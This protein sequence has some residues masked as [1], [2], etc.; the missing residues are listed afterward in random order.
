VN[1][2]IQGNGRTRFSD[3]SIGELVRSIAGDTATLVRKE[4]QLARQEMTETVTGKARGA[5]AFAAAG[6]L[7]LIALVFLGAAGAAALDLVL[8]RWASRLIVAGVFLVAM[9]VLIAAGAR[10]MSRTK[11]TANRTRKT[12]KEDMEWAKERLRR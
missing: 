12:V 6:I 10:L 1:K 7:A 3:L 5:V 9:A 8:P 4:I 11:V 2:D